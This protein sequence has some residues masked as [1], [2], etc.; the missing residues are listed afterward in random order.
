MEDII[1]HFTYCEE[2]GKL[3][4]KS[5]GREA[6]GLHKGSGTSKV[7]PRWRVYFKGRE[8]K[9]YNVAFLIKTG[10]W[11]LEGCSIDHINRDSTDDRWSNLRELTH[12][13]QLVNTREL[14]ANNNSGI[15]GVHWCSYWSRWI[16]ETS[17]NGKRK[18]LL[19]TA[20][21]F[22]ACCARKAYELSL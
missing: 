16:A 22:E 12:R 8:Y 15:K 3:F 17:V 4:L 5:S 21:F 10:R 18:G 2:T 13:Q 1:N 14:R 11:P 6:G 9:R 19:H 20:D 7:A